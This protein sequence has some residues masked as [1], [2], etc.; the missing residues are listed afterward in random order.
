MT[1]YSRLAAGVALGALLIAAPIASKVFAADINGGSTKDTMEFA[2]RGSVVNWTGFYVGGQVGYGINTMNWSRTDN[3][4]AV[5]REVE[6]AASRCWAE[7]AKGFEDIGNPWDPNDERVHD[8]EIHAG[9]SVTNVTSD[10]CDQLRAML[11][12]DPSITSGYNAA[13]EAHTEVVTPAATVKTSGKE[14]DSGLLGGARVGYDQALGR[15]VVGVFGDYN[16]SAVEGLDGQ[17]LAAARAG[18]IVAP[19][20]LL[21]GLVGYGQSDYDGVDF[22]G[23]TVGGGVEFAVSDNVFLG[24]EYQHAFYDTETLVNT[25]NLKIEADAEEDRI[26]GTLKIKLNGFGR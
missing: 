8:A 19:R 12:N 17:W 14:S 4:P 13:V 26:M 11:P 15:I 9:A 7:F 21:Y 16:W 5:T 6:A 20:T 22:K 2:E 24:L 1:T 18:F 10:E 23:I 25:P 3:F